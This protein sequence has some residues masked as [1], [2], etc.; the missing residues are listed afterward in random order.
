[1]GDGQPREASSP[2]AAFALFKWGVTQLSIV[3]PYKA[4]WSVGRLVRRAACPPRAPPRRTDLGAEPDRSRA[5]AEP[6]S[7]RRGG[8]TG[9]AGETG[10][11][12]WMSAPAERG[13]CRGGRAGRSSAGRRAPQR[14]RTFVA[15]TYL[16]PILLGV[17]L[18][19]MGEK[20]VHVGKVRSQS[21]RVSGGRTP[22]PRTPRSC[23]RGG[24]GGR[25]CGTGGRSFR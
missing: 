24:A 21:G 13:A 7:A 10:P 19:K 11:R 6:M 15:W 25:A 3:C 14:E 1:M 5:G 17:E 12:G 22:R 16:S 23:T 4:G 20:Y 18:R 9:G 2:V 8:D